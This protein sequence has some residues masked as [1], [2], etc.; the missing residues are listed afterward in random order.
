M[1]RTT[2][3]V[4]VCSAGC[5]PAWAPSWV[6]AGP[7]ERCERRHESPHRATAPIAD[8][9]MTTATPM[10]PRV[11]RTSPA[12]TENP[13]W[14]GSRLLRPTRGSWTIGRASGRWSCRSARRSKSGSADNSR[15]RRRSGRRKWSASTDNRRRKWSVSGVKWRPRRTKCAAKNRSSRRKRSNSTSSCSS[16]NTRCSSCNASSGSVSRATTRR[17]TTSSLRAPLTPSPR[18]QLEQCR[19]HPEWLKETPLAS[20]SGP[21]RCCRSSRA[22]PTSRT[23]LCHPPVVGAHTRCRLARMHGRSLQQTV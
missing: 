19:R 9:S 3:Q 1:V 12:T 8:T 6:G 10:V 7:L 14:T 13:R 21:A 17:Q 11:S 2:D 16:C 4:A 18:P 22:I 23:P 5:S 20:D 15:S